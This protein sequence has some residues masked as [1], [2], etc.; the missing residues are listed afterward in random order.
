MIGDGRINLDISK[1]DLGLFLFSSTSRVRCRTTAVGGV[2]AS[3]CTGVYSQGDDGGPSTD[4]EPPSLAVGQVIHMPDTAVDHGT[5]AD[6]PLTDCRRGEHH[7]HAAAS[8]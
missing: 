4:P 1:G 7:T 3:L 5:A 2:W 8:V 6:D